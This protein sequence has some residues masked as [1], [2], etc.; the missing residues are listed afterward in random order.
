MGSANF[1]PHQLSPIMTTQH[2]D[3]LRRSLILWS[4]LCLSS[5]FVHAQQ[6]TDSGKQLLEARYTKVPPTI[7]GVVNAEEWSG[8]QTHAVD[9]VKLGVAGNSGPM[10]SDGPEDISYTFRVLYDDTYL[11]IGVTVKD[12][13]YVSTNYGRRLQ[14]D[15]PVTW[16]NDAV[17]YFFDGDFSQSEGSSRTPLESETGGQWIFGIESDDAPL[18]FVSPVLYGQKERPFGTGANDVWYARTTVDKNSADWQQEARF[19][20]STIGSPS[21]NSQIGF[22]IGV[23]DVDTEDPESMTV[24]HYLEVRDIQLYWTVFGYNTGDTTAENTHE[25]ETLWGVMKFMPPT[26]GS[27]SVTNVTVTN[28]KVSGDKLELS[29]TTPKPSGSHVVEQT[30]KLPASLWTEVPN[31]TFSSGTG[32]TLVATF[33]KPSDSPAFYRVRPL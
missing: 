31:V 33:A 17:E 9:F 15:L 29:F 3:T 6:T 32:N 5:T 25:L 28:I 20:L 12:D 2:V 24:D 26:D 19:K 1:H 27:G 4:A 13:I 21:A 16:E 18:P 11:Y 22:N 7:D 14:W 10:T 30:A 8:A 23:D